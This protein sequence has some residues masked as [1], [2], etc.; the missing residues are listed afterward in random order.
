METIAEPI[1]EKKPDV[2]ELAANR[3]EMGFGRTILA[4]ER[5]MMA[6]IR[7]D[8]SL[9]SFGFTIYKFL[10]TMQQASG[11]PIHGNAPRNLGMAL[12]LLGVGTLIMAMIQFKRAINRIAIFSQNE[13][14]HSLSIITGIG[15][16]VVAFG[17]LLNMLGMWTG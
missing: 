5:T 10:E 12:I 14:Q 6:W 13:R 7:T 15:F 2:N 4:L 16:L 3:T 17:M 1:R 9:I 11:K 8:L